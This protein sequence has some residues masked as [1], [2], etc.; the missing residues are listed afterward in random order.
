MHPRGIL[1]PSRSTK[2]SWRRVPERVVGRTYPLRTSCK[3]YNPKL[4]SI[5]LRVLVQDL[6]RVGHDG[7]SLGSIDAHG[8]SRSWDLD[9]R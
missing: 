1:K 9:S 5:G 3:T 6:A 4:Q 2:G 8:G 7:K